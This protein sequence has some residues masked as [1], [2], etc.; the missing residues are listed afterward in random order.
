MSQQ[1]IKVFLGAYINSTNA[2]NLNCQAL[3]QHLDKNKFQIYTLELYSGNLESKKGKIPG[4]KIFNCFRPFKVSK[5]LGF[6]WGIWH[7]DVAYLPK[8]ELNN[9]TTFFLKLFSKKSFST[10]EGVFD[11]ENL[12]SAHEIHGSYENFLKSLKGFDKLYSI[13]N[14][15]KTYNFKN[16]HI[17]TEQKILY[18]GCETSIFQSNNQQNAG[19]KS[20]IYIG[21]LK[22]RKG[23]YDLVTLAEHFPD[24]EFNVYGNGEEYDE[25]VIMLK[26]KKLKNFN[27]KGTV[28]H[29]EL[30][31]ALQNSDLH[32]LPSRS[33]GFPKVTL[34]TAAAGVPSVVYAD[35]GAAEW[36]T[37]NKNGFVVESLED[38]IATINYLQENPQDLQAISKNAIALAQSFDWKVLVKDWEEEIIKLS[39]SNA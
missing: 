24:L 2:Q 15:L 21:R 19:L 37:H 8:R 11:E 38:T 23:I 29:T 9:W 27:L 36:I 16:H 30:A 18:L 28:T 7:C 6:L 20:I 14:F 25:L 32:I 10:V 34:E 5:Y 13:T 22:K 31:E 4:V 17:K 1:K 12:K 33:E 3:A 35:Y 26:E 39:R